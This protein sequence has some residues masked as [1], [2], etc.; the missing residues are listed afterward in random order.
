MNKVDELSAKLHRL[1][2]ELD[3]K[4]HYITA[5]EKANREL[6]SRVRGVPESP[7]P[8]PAS[9]LDATLQRL[10]A[11]I[12]AIL[13][14][15][16]C[17]FLLFDRESGDLIPS[18]PAIG[19]GDEELKLLRVKATQGVS[20]QVFRERKPIL[21]Y[22]AI[23]DAR[24]TKEHAALLKIRNSL[25][26]P[27]IGERR[28]EENGGA[29][30]APIG[31]LHVFNKLY[32]S[33]FDEEDVSLLQRLAK[34][35]TAVI[36][37]AQAFREIAAE[38]QELETIVESAYTGLLMVSG[39]GLIL[40][41]NSSARQMFG[42]ARSDVVGRPYAEVIESPDVKEI[43]TRGVE[44]AEELADEV[45][46]A[47]SGADGKRTLQM[48]T[49]LVRGEDETLIACVAIFNDV[50]EIR[51]IERMKTAFVSTVS[52]ELRTPLT[53]IKGF[54]A[55]LLSDNEGYYD[56][57]TRREFYRIVD[58]ECDRL[59]R[60]VSDLLNVSRI[61][62]GRG[63]ELN[64]RRVDLPKLIEKVATVQKSY[65]DKHTFKVEIADDVPMIFADEDKVDQIL[66]NLTSN[67]IKYSPDGGEITI[68]AR[69]HGDG[70]LCSIADRG[71]GIP[72]EH[73]P[74]VFDR[75][76]RVDTRDAREVGGTGIGLYLVKHLVEAHGGQVWV[77]SEYGEGSKFT[78]TLP[79]KPPGRGAGPME[80]APG[81]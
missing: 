11:K 79:G 73:L 14:A 39:S 46:M 12:T 68:S 1:Q 17:A 52:H 53:S 65:A 40:Q 13:Q 36:Q 59:I 76:H 47:I 37:N 32:D 33:V 6:E 22:D 3:E 4:K 51:N 70:V 38:K 69:G 7:E 74:K 54:A 60:L 20:G 61:E 81:D 15:E 9:D 41:M 29:R 21:V 27:L 25:S 42:V 23:T 78:F 19:F 43:I 72:P 75:Y 10:V 24:T 80:E 31:V 55:T 71:M 45:S 8:T 18:K 56:E 64:P 16:K 50:T 77:E 58:E 57:D 2:R 26:V 63:L 35:A 5:L 66:T 62:A 48:Q 44:D 30:T 49:A 28:D 67:A 34:S